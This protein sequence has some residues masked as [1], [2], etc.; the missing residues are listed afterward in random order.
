MKII[1]SV[2]LLSLCALSYE[3]IAQL[4]VNTCENFSIGTVL[5]FRNCQTSGVYHGDTGANQTWDF[6]NLST[7]DTVTEWVLSPSATPHGSMYPTATFVEKHSD[8]T[9]V[10]AHAT[11]DSGYLVGFEDSVNQFVIQYSNSML[12]AVRPISYGDTATDSFVMNYSSSSLNF[13]GKGQS[14]IIADG[15]GT[16]IL[17]NASYSNVLRLKI[18]Q[19]EADTSTPPYITTIITY[20][21][22]DNIHNSALLKIDSTNS[23]T[24][25]SQDVLYMISEAVPTGVKQVS[26]EENLLYPNPVRDMAYFETKDKG[27]ITITNQIGQLAGSFLV[28][29]DVTEIPTNNITAGLYYIAFQTEKY[30]QVL[31]LLVQ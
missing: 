1:G 10:Y 7:I 4:T 29:K 25:I 5:K 31:K 20:G 23:P 12:F 14:S 28:E 30:R 18:M 19:V 27:A 17:P 16:L 11:A 26:I 3:S 22:W 21:W 15:Y 8:G 24:Y 13:P 6:S 2:L 9:Y